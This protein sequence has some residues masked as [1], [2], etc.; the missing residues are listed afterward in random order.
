MPTTTATWMRMARTPATKAATQRIRRNLRAMMA[1][2]WNFSAGPS[3][4]PE[5]VLRQAAAEMLDWNGSG[6]SVME[7]SHRGKHFVQICD[8][9]ESDLRELLSLPADYAVMFMQ[10]G[11]SGKRHCSHESHGT[12]RHAGRGLRR[13]GPLVQA[14]ARRSRALR[15]RPHRRQQRPGDAAGRPRAGPVHLGA[16]HRYLAGAQGIRLSAPVQ[17]RDHRRRGIPRLARHGR[18][19]RARCAAGRGCVLAFPVASAGRRALRHGV[20]RRAEERRPGRRDHGHRPPRP[21]RPRL[22]DLPV[23]LR[24]CQCRRRALALQHAA[25]LRDLHRRA[26]V[27]VGQ[28]QRRRGRH[29]SRQQGQGRPAVRLPG[30]HQLLPQS[31]PRARARA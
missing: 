25:H 14:F 4:L 20:R 15:Q 9:A 11:G 10:G 23:G 12:P 5:V 24:L 19:G 13:H 6:M 2:P 18:A 17:Q 3:A 31:D 1:R 22:A 29:G 7:M 8:E 26:G 27:Q 16:R 30:Q 28:G 21:D